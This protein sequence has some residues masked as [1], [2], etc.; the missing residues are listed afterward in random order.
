MTPSAALI[1]VKSKYL[2]TFLYRNIYPVIFMWKKQ[3]HNAQFLSGF[4]YMFLHFFSVIFLY[5]FSDTAGD[6]LYCK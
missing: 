3:I 4:I 2:T 1:F 6:P 5:Y